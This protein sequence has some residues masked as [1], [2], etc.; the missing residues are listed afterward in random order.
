[1]GE[2]LIQAFVLHR[3]PYRESSLLVEAL[4]EGFCRVAR[5][6]ISIASV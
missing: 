3:R 4:T 5:F 1:M 6:S 2:P